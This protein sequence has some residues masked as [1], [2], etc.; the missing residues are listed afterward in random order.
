MGFLANHKELIFTVIIAPL[1]VA[2]IS[3]PFILMY[4][5]RSWLL[6]ILKKI[7][8]KH[9][10]A[11]FTVALSIKFNKDLN[12]GN[13]FLEIKKQFASIIGDLDL[14][15]V[16]SI[17]DFSDIYLF[18][19]KE[20]AEQYRNKKN[21]DLLIWGSFSEDGL[22]VDGE[23]VSKMKLNFTYG[24]PRNMN[25]R[26]DALGKA[27]ILDIGSRLAIKN[28][29][30]ILENN[31]YRDV[32][33]VS[34]NLSDIAMYIIGLTLKFSGRL[35]ESIEIFEKLIYKLT[36]KEDDFKNLVIPQLID[37]YLLLIQDIVSSKKSPEEG[38]VYCEKI[39]KLD[40]KNFIALTHIAL[41]YYRAGRRWD[42][43]EIVERL[44]QLYPKSSVTEL[45][46]AFIR[47]MQKNYVNAFKHYENLSAMTMKDITFN[48]QDAIEFLSEQ[49]KHS[50]E[51]ALLYGSGVVSYYFG[52]K[53]VAKEDFQKFVDK[54]NDE[55][56]GKMFREAKRLLKTL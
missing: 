3:C 8:I 52:D 13:Y 23:N 6:R 30:Q 5:H 28:Y 36:V 46:V 18:L 22:K 20:E 29:W 39:L 50:K 26:H 12:S 21:L 1:V 34:N 2:A 45:D 55:K 42:C 40:E 56:Y 10:P 25:D 16:I 53:I 54:A 32:E 4:R 11:K 48:P 14:S 19:S 49:Y 47:V 38:I 7:K 44:L 27:I 31:S 43:D 17:E 9:F 37:C 15:N 33:I 35:K 51:I 41:F 24:Y